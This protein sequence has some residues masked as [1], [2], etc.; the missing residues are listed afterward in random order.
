MTYTGKYNLKELIWSYFIV[1]LVCQVSG[2]FAMDFSDEG[3]KDET[4]SLISRDTQTSPLSLLPCEVLVLI[5]QELD[6][7][8]LTQMERTCHRFKCISQSHDAFIWRHHLAKSPL[9]FYPNLDLKRPLSMY[10]NWRSVVLFWPMLTH[11][12]QDKIEDESVEQP[13]NPLSYFISHILSYLNSPEEKKSLNPLQ[14]LKSFIPEGEK[15]GESDEEVRACL[16]PYSPNLLETYDQYKIFFEDLI[17]V[18][19]SIINTPYEDA[20]TQCYLYCQNVFLTR[21]L[22]SFWQ[23]FPKKSAQSLI[24]ILNTYLW[25]EKGVGSVSLPI[26]EFRTRVQKLLANDGER[27][28]VEDLRLLQLDWWE[29]MVLWYGIGESSYKQ[30]E[31][32]RIQ[33]IQE[34][35]FMGNQQAPIFLANYWFNTQQK[36]PLIAIYQQTQSPFYIAALDRLITP[37]IDLL[38]EE[39]RLSLALSGSLQAQ[40]KILSL[41]HHKDR[42]EP[43]RDAFT[44]L[45]FLRKGAPLLNL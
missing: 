9:D 40:T 19:G 24:S 3:P 32:T 14:M 38:D 31:I 26:P 43:L 10:T 18:E 33:K 39:K 6:T 45:N 42:Q 11:Y 35:C 13:S 17:L 30:P 2:C 7:D 16:E 27:Y 29:L 22:G 20:D 15:L 41:I 21:F 25:L 12:I 28:K 4:P 37:Q 23:S 1:I 44:V 34:L 8:S 36:D 5:M